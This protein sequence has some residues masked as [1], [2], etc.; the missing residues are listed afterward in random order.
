MTTNT[1]FA[2]GLHFKTVS[3]YQT[4]SFSFC[5]ARFRAAR[6]KA[7]R[8]WEDSERVGQWPPLSG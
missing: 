8:Y 2:N 6:E 7:T 4:C 1:G 3:R 5:I